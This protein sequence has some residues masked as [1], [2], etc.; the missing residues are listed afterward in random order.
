MT[1]VDEMTNVMAAYANGEHIEFRLADVDTTESDWAYVST[2]TWNWHKYEY[3]IAPSKKAS[4]RLMTNSQLSELLQKGYGCWGEKNSFGYAHAGYS[5][6]CNEEDVPVTDKLIRPWGSKEW[7]EPTE[8]IY[9][10]YVSRWNKA[11]GVGVSKME[12]TTASRKSSYNESLCDVK[13]YSNAHPSTIEPYVSE[14]FFYKGKVYRC[15]SSDE[16]TGCA[17]NNEE[18]LPSRDC[19]I[20]RCYRSN[21]RDE[22]SVKFV[23]E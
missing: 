16:C 22:N 19:S 1:N 3:R 6:S 9:N 2:P 17:F 11:F 21:R 12:K 20:F 14:R 8:D 10:A 15:V 5:F 7:I 13:D 23:E 4:E 18:R